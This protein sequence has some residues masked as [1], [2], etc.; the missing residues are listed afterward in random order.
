MSNEQTIQGTVKY[1]ANPAQ[2]KDHGFGPRMN[3]AITTANGL[4]RVYATVGTPQG[5][6]L[7]G[8]QKGQQVSIITD[9]KFNFVGLAN[10]HQQSQAPPQAPPPQVPG[11]FQQ[12]PANPVHQAPPP[13]GMNVSLQQVEAYADLLRACHDA[14]QNKFQDAGLP[15]DQEPEILSKYVHTLYISLTR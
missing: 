11:N 14:I 12:A 4:V 10:G 9:D 13:Q 15:I 3:A 8:L 6:Q 1:Y 7:A 2:A 5:D